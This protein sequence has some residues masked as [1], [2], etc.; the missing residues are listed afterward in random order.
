M[1][2]GP[3]AQPLESGREV[4]PECNT[5]HEQRIWKQTAPPSV[6]SK[7]GMVYKGDKDT[8]KPE[9]QVWSGEGA[10]FLSECA[11]IG[12]GIVAA[13]DCGAVYAGYEAWLE[14]FAK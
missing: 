10:P 5:S 7:V 12:A 14:A 11:T 9:D 4:S 6:S 2:N 1:Q 13:W 3:R 8:G